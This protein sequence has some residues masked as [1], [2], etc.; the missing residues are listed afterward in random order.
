[1][2]DDQLEVLACASDRNPAAI[3]RWFARSI[4]GR[5]GGGDMYRMLG[6]LVAWARVWER[7]RAKEKRQT[8]RITGFRG[9]PLH[10]G[11]KEGVNKIKW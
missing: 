10:F 11:L 6:A 4:G 8:K 9:C 5:G 1:M 2:Q 3:F 7:N